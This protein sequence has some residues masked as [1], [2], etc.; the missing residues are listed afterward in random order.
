MRDGETSPQSRP[1]T[2]VK[3]KELLGLT[4]MQRPHHAAAQVPACPSGA[5]PFAFD[6]QESDLVDRIDHPQTRL[7]SKQS[8][9]RI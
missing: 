5:E 9:M 7:N 6:A 1:L 2:A 3:D 8:I 4:V